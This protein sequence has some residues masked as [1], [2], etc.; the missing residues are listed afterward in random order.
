MH[1]AE[2]QAGTASSS[3]HMGSDNGIL[4]G[5]YHVLPENPLTFPSHDLLLTQAGEPVQLGCQPLHTFLGAAQ[6]RP[7]HPREGLAAS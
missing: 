7:A 3:K 5:S 1:R 2:V 4:H 6:L